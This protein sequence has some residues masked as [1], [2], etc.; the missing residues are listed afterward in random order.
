MGVD[1][2]ERRQIDHPLW[3]DPSIGHD[4]DCFGLDLLK[5]GT[6][7]GVVLDFVGLCYRNITLH[8]ETLDRGH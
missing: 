5:P 3:D 2:A 7:L 4:N 6:K 1:V 8:S